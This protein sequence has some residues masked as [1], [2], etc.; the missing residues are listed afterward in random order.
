[1]ANTRKFP[2][3]L[4]LTKSDLAMI[5]LGIKLLQDNKTKNVR[6]LAKLKATHEPGVLVSRNP[7][8]DVAIW[9]EIAVAAATLAW[10]VYKAWKS[11][12]VLGANVLPAELLN[13]M[14]VEHDFSID[15]LITAREQ[16]NRE[17]NL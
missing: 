8:G 13:R 9:V 15:Q 10:E 3:K 1:M 11:G 5:D 6:D 17:M 7:G 2:D 12:A 14:K 4:T 16:I